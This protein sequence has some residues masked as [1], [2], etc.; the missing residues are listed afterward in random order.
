MRM[1]LG[2]GVF[3]GALLVCATAF[4]QDEGIK[5]RLSSWDTQF[6]MN[7]AVSQDPLPGTELSA[8]MLGLR[9]DRFVPSFELI[10]YQRRFKLTLG[11][12]EALYEGTEQLTTKIDFE[13]ETYNVSD[14]VES[15]LRMTSYDL[16]AQL[17]LISMSKAELGIVGGVRVFKYYVRITDTTSAFAASDEAY[18]GSPYIGG[19]VEFFVQNLF[20]VGANI[21]AFSYANEK[22]E[23]KLNPYVDINFYTEFR[24]GSHIAARAGYSNIK[25]GFEKTGEDAVDLEYYIKGPYFGVY[26]AF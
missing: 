11:Y 6:N 7:L 15:K 24:I 14:V 8:D 22:A 1:L 21:V 19:A 5:L 12:W 26:I 4:A 23:F 18:A 3:V 10:F 25:L 20:V 16:R 2:A 13:G 9:N 17:N